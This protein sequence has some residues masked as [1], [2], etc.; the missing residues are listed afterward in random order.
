MGNKSAPKRPRK[1]VVPRTAFKKG[2]KPGPGRP[3][4]PE[5][6]KAAKRLT[7]LQLQEIGAALIKQSLED[8]KALE[9]HPEATALQ[10][11]LIRIAVHAIEHRDADTL[12][13]LLDRF[14]GRVGERHEFTGIPAPAAPAAPMSV[15]PTIVVNVPANGREKQ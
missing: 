4:L 11:W 6:H 13:K 2:C 12:N 5:A 1:H 15:A 14:V 8:L 9:K 7:A 10:V 3:P